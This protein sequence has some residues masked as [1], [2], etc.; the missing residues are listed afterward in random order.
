MDKLVKSLRKACELCYLTFLR[1]LMTYYHLFDF[2]R[3]LVLYSYN[4]HF[5]KTELSF[6]TL[7]FLQNPFR[8]SKKFQ[9]ER[10]ETDLHVYGETPLKT[11]DKILTRCSILSHDTIYDLGCGRGRT[12]FWMNAFIGCKALG[13]DW[14]PHFIS[15]AQKIAKITRTEKITFLCSDFLTI[16]FSSATAVY[17]FGTCLDEVTIYKLVEKLNTL[18][19]GAKVISVSYSIGEY[20]KK[21]EFEECQ[22][23]SVRFPWGKT[24]VFLSIKN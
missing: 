5:L 9:K 1:I 24:D 3:D 18:P 8:I 13:V 14:N 2:L 10:C 7:Y 20:A 11:L 22:S 12:T 19:Q 15:K 21:G 4:L 16:D 23:F 17:L 6:K